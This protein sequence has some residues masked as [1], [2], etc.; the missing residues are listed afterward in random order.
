MNKFILSILALS[1]SF[2]SCKEEKIEEDALSHEDIESLN[3]T[4]LYN[5]SEI[6]YEGTYEGNIK[7][8][9]VILTIT[10]EGFEVSE[11]GK[12]ALGT[13]VRIDDG[14]IIELSPSSGNVAVKFY[15]WSDNDNWIALSDEGEY[16]EKEEFLHRVK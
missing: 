1:L 5:A 7:G 9:E 8:K 15:G 14:T 4:S 10:D 11:G 6:N 16:P 3:D 2:I 13:W 12:K